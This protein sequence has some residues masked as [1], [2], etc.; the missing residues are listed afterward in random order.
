ME[1]N[2]TTPVEEVQNNETT[3]VKEEVVT[4]T[5]LE[6]VKEETSKNDTIIV[7]FTNNEINNTTTNT[8][9]DSNVISGIICL[10]LIGGGIYWVY[11]KCC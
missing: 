9:E 7:P 11:K 3:E 1:E 8:S 6:E 10:G 2:I 5:P 4:E